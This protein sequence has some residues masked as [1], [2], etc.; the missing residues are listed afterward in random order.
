MFRDA[1]ASI[2]LVLV[3]AVGAGA[4]SPGVPRLIPASGMLFDAA[5]KPLSG[6]NVKITFAVYAGAD[7]EAALWTET[8]KVT[9]T[10]GRY[11]A[12]IGSSSQDGIPAT[13]F[14]GGEPRWLAVTADKAV[15]QPRALLVS[16]PYAL[17][18][19]D[20]AKLGG[21]PASA[22]VLKSDAP[23]ASVSGG[24]SGWKQAVAEETA[25]RAGADETLQ[26]NVD[27]EAAA[28]TA[29]DAAEKSARESAD[30]AEESARKAA[31]ADEKTQREAAD[32]DEKAQREN[33]DAAEK[34]ARETKDGE[35]QGKLDGAKGELDGRID[36]TK[37]ELNAKI[38]NTR[39]D[40]NGKIA[41][42]NTKLSAE[43]DAKLLALK[44][45]LKTD[46]NDLDQKKTSKEEFEQEKT[47]KQLELD[48]IKFKKLEKKD[49]DDDRAAKQRA[50]DQLELQKLAKDEYLLDKQKKD[51]DIDN[52]KQQKVDKLEYLAEKAA[53]DAAFLDLKEKKLEKLAF[54]ADK[55]SKEATLKDL[56]DRVKE[57]KTKADSLTKFVVTFARTPNQGES[58][59]VMRLCPDHTVAIGIV[60][61]AS[62]PVATA[63]PFCA[64]VAGATLRA[65][66][67]LLATIVGPY[68]VPGLSAIPDYEL[69]CPA[70]FAV[71]GVH[72]SE[73]AMFAQC[74]RLFGT[75][76]AISEA[77]VPAAIG[78]VNACTADTTVTGL[79][80]ASGLAMICG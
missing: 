74:R 4:Q 49:F 21:L 59:P 76:E 24:P 42:E 46:S 30:A 44:N 11:D 5:G 65:D 64:Q 16:V 57:L 77:S 12:L 54:E 71:T 40:L 31:D 17:T 53:R 14:S 61:Q 15:N 23:A 73:G 45:E 36:A 22:F 8:L 51:F 69:M 13:V 18:S 80:A 70:G 33:A 58:G 72:S 27:A 43:Q 55:A 6:N 50:L 35:L 79:D 29:E 19:D 75:E 47:K 10:A 34:S 66:G 7:E 41:F 26:G 78:A 38:D 28:R 9:V 25:A 39:N 52:L 37:A 32:A 63:S 56:D 48:D 67:R 2:L 3:C 60:G 20:A 1:I 62:N 68:A